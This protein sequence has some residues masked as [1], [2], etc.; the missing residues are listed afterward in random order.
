MKMKM[1]ES[2]MDLFIVEIEWIVW[3][4]LLRIL[5]YFSISFI[6]ITYGRR[7]DEAVTKTCSI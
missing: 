5:P 4:I 7:L 2:E 3:L 6:N 1:R